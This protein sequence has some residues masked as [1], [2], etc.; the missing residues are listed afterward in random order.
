MI[1]PRSRWGG[2]NTAVWI[3]YDFAN[4]ILMITFFMYFSQW[5]VIERGVTDLWFNLLFVFSTILLLIAAPPLAAWADGC[6]KMLPFLR[7][8]TVATGTF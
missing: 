8:S 2:T 6:G 5:L 3:L 7:W 1:G 4:S